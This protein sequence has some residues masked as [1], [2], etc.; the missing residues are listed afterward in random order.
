MIY[1]TKL[2]SPQLLIH[3]M[4]GIVQIYEPEPVLS[5]IIEKLSANC[6]ECDVLIFVRKYKRVAI[7]ML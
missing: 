7:C 6:K 1:D 3:R 5:V 4:T 2:K